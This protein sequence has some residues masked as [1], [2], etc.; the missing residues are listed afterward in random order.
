MIRLH[1]LNQSRSLR[2]LWLL[3]E[4]GVPY[5]I[6]S[7]Q[8]DADT[9]LA[10]DSLKAIHPLGKSPVIEMD[11]QLY[12]ESGA[13]TELLIERFAPERLRP[14]TDSSDYGYYLQWIDF[15]ESSLMLP[16]MLEL[17]T[18]KAGIDDNEFLNGYI[19]TEK[20]RLFEYLDASVEGKSF[21]VGDKL[22]GADFMLSFDLIILAKRQKLDAYPHIKQY[23]EQLASLDS[24][25]RAMQLEAKYDESI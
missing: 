22:S 17:F 10:P 2:I 13:I 16:L 19:D 7:H 21:I 14:A 11:G 24:Y 23:A 15:A 6:I 18:K 20:T 4:L 1:H 9:H 25:Q 3:E 12:A 8:R 5:E